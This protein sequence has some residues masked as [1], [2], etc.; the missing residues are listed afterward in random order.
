MLIADNAVGEHRPPAP[1]SEGV[2]LP[3][4]NHCLFKL[5]LPLG[6]LWYLSDL[7]E[8]LDRAGRTRFFLSAPP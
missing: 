5:G 8:W 3:L 7:A 2:L 1:R 6:E 4:H